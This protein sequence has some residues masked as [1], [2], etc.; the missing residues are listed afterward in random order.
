MFEGN[1]LR[2]SLKAILIYKKSFRDSLK[3]SN[4]KDMFL[5]VALRIPMIKISPLGIFLRGPIVKT[6]S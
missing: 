5:G 3:E 6:S 4:N 2:D 1:P